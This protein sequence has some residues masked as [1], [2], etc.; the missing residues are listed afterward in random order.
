V[1][2]QTRT[3]WIAALFAGAA[4]VLSWAFFSSSGRQQ[5]AQVEYQDRTFTEEAALCQTRECVEIARRK[6]Y[7]W[8]YK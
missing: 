1:T 8:G 7:G 6:V 5:R 4:G 3:L 2:K